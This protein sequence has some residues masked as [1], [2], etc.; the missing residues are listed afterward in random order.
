MK[1]NK[2]T[3]ATVG[4]AVIAATVAFF[5]MTGIV[6]EG[7][8]KVTDIDE[9]RKAIT[10]TVPEE[11]QADIYELYFEDA[12]IDKA[13]LPDGKVITVPVLLA[14]PELLNVKIYRLREMIGT[15][16]LQ[17]DGTIKLKVKRGAVKGD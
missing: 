5:S 7:T 10:I 3:T 2:K 16:E 15:G 6:M 17:E 9:N 13:L 12:L 11:L 4:A 1:K 8:Y 14:K